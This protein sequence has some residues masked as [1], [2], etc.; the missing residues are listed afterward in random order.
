MTINIAYRGTRANH[1]KCGIERYVELNL[2]DT[3]VYQT[4]LLQKQDNSNV[5]KEIKPVV[6]IRRWEKLHNDS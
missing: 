2:G 5:Q 1:K 3:L 6:S 4:N